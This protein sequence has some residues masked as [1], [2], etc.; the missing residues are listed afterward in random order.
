[1]IKHVYMGQ[2]PSQRTQKGMKGRQS[3]ARSVLY[4]NEEIVEAC[5]KENISGMD[6]YSQK[7]GIGEESLCSI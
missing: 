6:S 1:M 2:A 4:M 5:R 7:Y 3:Q